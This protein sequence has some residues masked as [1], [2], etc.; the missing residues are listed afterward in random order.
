LEDTAYGRIEEKA[1]NPIE[2]KGEVALKLED[3]RRRSLN[4]V[5]VL[6]LFVS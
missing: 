4:R 6:I 3:K 1:R 2:S 5:L